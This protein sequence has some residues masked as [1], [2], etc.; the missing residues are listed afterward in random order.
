MKRGPGL[1]GVIV[2]VLILMGAWVWWTLDPDAPLIAPEDR[3]RIEVLPLPTDIALREGFLSLSGGLAVEFGGHEEPRLLRAAER[4]RQRLGFAGGAGGDPA[5][6]YIEVAAPADEEE[7]LW[8]DESYALDITPD[9]AR[10]RARTPLGAMHG[11]HTFEQLAERERDSWRVPA[12]RVRDAPRFRWRGLMIDVCRH[13]IPKEVIL[14]NLD[15]MDAAKMNVLH[16]HLSEDQAFRV[17]SRVHPRLHEVAS[18][19]D[20]FTQEDIAEIVT[21]AR[22]R[23]IRVIPEF[24]LPGHSRSWLE[25]YPSLA[26]ESGAWTRPNTYGIHPVALDPTREETWEFLDAFFGEM[27]GLFPDPV[28]H[29]GG[30]EAA[31]DLWERSPRIQAFMAERGFE[32]TSE[33]QGWFQGRLEE[34][35]SG[36][37]KTAMGWEEIAGP[38][39]PEETIVQAWRSPTALVE[40][41]RGGQRAVLSHGYYLDHKQPASFHYAVDPMGIPEPIDIPADQSWTSWETTVNSPMGAIES[42]FVVWGEGA[43]M[44]GA[45]R[46]EMG[47]ILLDDVHIDAGVLRAT[48]STPVGEM[49]VRADLSGDA[50]EGEFSSMVF[51]ATFRG[52]R[53]A[54]S[55][56]PGATPPELRRSIDIPPDARYRVLGGEAAMWSEVVDAQTVDSRIWPRTAAIAERLWSPAVSTGDEQDLYRRLDAFSVR[57]EGLGIRHEAFARDWLVEIGREANPPPAEERDSFDRALAALLSALEE[58][59]GYERFAAFGPDGLT[60][61][62]RLDRAADAAG[63]E[64]RKARLFAQRVD[65]FLAG[66]P[67]ALPQLAAQLVAWRDQYASLD[68]GFRA[69]ER[70][71]AIEPLS[72]SLSRVAALGLEALEHLGVG[73]TIDPAG[74]PS[75]RTLLAGA[76]RSVDGARLAPV[77]AISRLVRAAEA[78]PATGSEADEPE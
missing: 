29:V 8:N 25:A 74:D 10:L 38:E 55:D 9:E 3:A 12:A 45:S 1:I 75:R 61:T 41:V 20:Y 21:Y 68:V 37:G 13:W 76:D 27:A 64:S 19:G 42:L 66:D 65:A 43:D 78:P 14:R 4:M 57:L 72:R 52:R 28:V 18:D 69:S 7:P 59:R 32:T 30:D 60:T 31:G 47:V 62:T 46:S 11:L 24:D 39:R 67:R 54:G 49:E 16:L 71:A 63:P 70:L 22:D 58:V 17:E 48:A 36:H 40:A 26:I 34:I 5:R 2:F 6:L 51:S 23:G 73:D 44:R 50:I 56:Q 15:A 35:L 77:E 33:L 53:A